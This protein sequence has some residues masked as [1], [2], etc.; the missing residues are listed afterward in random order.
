MRF[1]GAIFREEWDDFQYSYLGENGLTNV[2]NAGQAQITGVETYVDWAATEQWRF[3]AG[4]TWLD[5]KL[6]QNFCQAIDEDPCSPENFANKGTRLPVTP[7]FKG[8][9]IAR[10]TFN[11]GDYDG[12][13]QG[14]YAIRTM[15]RPNCCRKTGSSPASR[16]LSETADFSASLRKGEYSLTLFINNAFDEHAD[17]YK[18]QECAVEVCGTAG[19]PGVGRHTGVP[20]LLAAAPVHDLYRDKPAADDWTDLPAGVLGA[21]NGIDREAGREIGPLSFA[22]RRLDINRT[23]SPPSSVVRA[24]THAHRQ[25]IER[26]ARHSAI[27]PQPESR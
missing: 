14:S 18:Y 3:S 10:D 17:L 5:P 24:Y 19:N 20:R 23:V 16:T 25:R 15:S 9:L 26:A 12:D 7:T 1:N 2:R 4:A 22:P 8:N 27:F 21:R 11:I 13:V 6:T